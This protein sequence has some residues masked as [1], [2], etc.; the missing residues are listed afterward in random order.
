[1]KRTALLIGLCLTLASAAAAD[2]WGPWEVR[3]KDL[4]AATRHESDGLNP[5]KA[6]VRFFQKFVIT[7]YSIHYTK[8]YEPG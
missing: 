5:L 2:D 7:S 6:G 1:M 3:Q 4:P 8:L